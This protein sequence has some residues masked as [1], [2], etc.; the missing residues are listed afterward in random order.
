MTAGRRAPGGHPA[1]PRRRPGR[2]RRDDPLD[3]PRR[4]RGTAIDRWWSVRRSGAAPPVSI[5]CEGVAPSSGA[6]ERHPPAEART[7]TMPPPPVRPRLVVARCSP[8]ARRSGRTRT[9]PSSRP[10][11][12]HLHDHMR[13]S[14]EVLA[15]GGRRSSMRPRSRRQAPARPGGVGDQSSSSRQPAAPALGGREGYP[16]RGGDRRGRLRRSGDG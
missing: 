5:S 2:R 14:P 12:L 6:G 7:G 9:R 13:Q 3:L 4:S 15:K 11:T 8:P 10:G 1:T 16:A